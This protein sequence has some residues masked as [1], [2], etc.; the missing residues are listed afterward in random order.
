MTVQASGTPA[1]I[2][3]VAQALETGRDRVLLTAADQPGTRWTGAE[4][5]RRIGGATALLDQTGCPPGTVVPALMTTRPEAMAM[6]VAGAATGRPLAPLS[7]RLTVAELADCLADLDCPILLSEPGSAD[8]GRALAR[9]CGRRS[10]VVGDLPRADAPALTAAAEHTAF[11][12]HTSGTTGRPRRVD[13]RQDRLGA[14]AIVNARLTRLDTGSVYSASSPFH[15]IGGLGA[16]AVALAAGAEIV[17][18]PRFTVD[19][20]QSLERLGV[21]HAQ[22][23]PAMIEMLLRADAFALPS[24]RLLQYGAS[25][26]HPATLRRALAAMPGVAFVNLFGQTEGAPLTC[27]SPEDH[28]RAAAGDEE[29]LDSVGRPVEE[30]ELIIH[31]PDESGVGEVRARGAHLFAPGPDGWLHTGDLGRLDERGYLHLVGRKGDLI[32]RGGEN[33]H[34]LEVEQTLARHDAVE[35]AAVVGVPDERVGEAVMAFIVPRDPSAPPEPAELRAF[36]RT[37]L[38]GFKVPERWEFV[39]ALPRNPNGKVR[40]RDLPLPRS[41]Q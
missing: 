25:P 19:A 1:W 6:V 2:D 14:R 4:L 10:V 30:V 8:I 26:I 13:V 5:T 11:V 17:A 18:F 15:H 23:V 41:I 22:A 21:T 34:P 29:L 12:L 32:I 37:T 35:E 31:E 3:L 24:L 20:W 40:R 9:R 36:A 7:P 39:A 27:L 33:V 28:E 16:F 38:A